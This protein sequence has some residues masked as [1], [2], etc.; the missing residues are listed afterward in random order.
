M[1]VISFDRSQE[2][3]RAVL[4]TS[5]F[6]RCVFL[7]DNTAV[8]EQ[9]VSGTFANGVLFDFAVR[10]HTVY[11]YRTIRVLGSEGELNGR[12]EKGEIRI[13]RFQAANWQDP[14][15]T[16]IT[17]DPEVTDGHLGGDSSG[18]KHF[19]DC[20][21]NGDRATLARGLRTALEGHLLSFAAEE[22][23]AAARTVDFAEFNTAL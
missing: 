9:V 17:I 6:G 8:D 2:A 19:V 11:P 16:V 7:C 3:R 14:E 4:R 18:L 1:S 21:R 12:A 15:A 5:P 23:R 13:Q 10:A 20:L 22:A